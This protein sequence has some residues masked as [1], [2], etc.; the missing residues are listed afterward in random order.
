MDVIHS[1]PQIRARL[2]GE[3]VAFVPTMGNLHEGHLAL[4]RMAR[5]RG[6]CVVVSIF[7]NRLQFGPHEDFSRYPRT[8]E[9]DCARLAKL[10]VD[11]VFAPDDQE[12]YPEPQQFLV[13]PPPVANTLEG[14]FRPGFF[15]GV[16]TVVL[17][18]FNIVQ[19]WLAVFGKKDYQQLHII[20]AMVRQLALPVEILAG[21]TLRSQDGLALSSRNQYLS[22]EERVEAVRLYQV[23]SQIKHVVEA[24]NPHYSELETEAREVLDK[25]GWIVDYV[26][27]HNSVT[28]DPAKPGERDLVVLGAA[29][30]GGT[31]LIDNLEIRAQ[32]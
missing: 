27:L 23:L 1:I 25:R 6:S 31:R 26:A 10:G 2:K 21:E 3:A 5:Q 30:L 13:E 8:F 22:P 4:V 15:R 20:R 11:V 7:V 32:G 18:L 29:K 17:K 28:L 19:P 9:E 16:A 24:G 14:V 12:L